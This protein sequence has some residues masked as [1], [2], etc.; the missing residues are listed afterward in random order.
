MGER[1][2]PCSAAACAGWALKRLSRSA[3]ITTHTLER[4][5]AAA[6]IIGFSRRWNGRYKSPAATGMPTVL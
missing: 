1:G 2:A 4:L 5:M 3:F 6:P